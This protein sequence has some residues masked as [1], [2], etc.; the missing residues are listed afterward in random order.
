MPKTNCCA[1]T[2]CVVPTAFYRHFA[3]M[4]EL[5]LALVEESFRTLRT[6]L[7]EALTPLPEDAQPL[8]LGPWT[9]T[10]SVTDALGFAATREG[11]MISLI[12]DTAA[13]IRAGLRRRCPAEAGHQ[14][15]LPPE[16]LSRGHLHLR[17]P[18]P[19][20]VL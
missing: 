3:S 14:S 16:G 13:L 6:M 7:R 18:E 17:L 19:H 10:G 9:Y 1:W 12:P 5:G 11:S 2:S 8:P 20:R 15:V 4:D